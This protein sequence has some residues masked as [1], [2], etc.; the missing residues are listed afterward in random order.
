MSN[1]LT[2]G[3]D[4]VTIQNSYK[5]CCYLKTSFFG[6]INKNQNKHTDSCFVVFR[7]KFVFEFQILQMKGIL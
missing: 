1:L 6:I 5:M 2:E 7:S 4:V 3:K